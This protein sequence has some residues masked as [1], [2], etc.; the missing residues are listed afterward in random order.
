MEGIPSISAEHMTSYG[1]FDFSS[2]RYVPKEFYNSMS[3]GHITKNDI[4]IVKDGAT[5]GKVCL[6][7][8]ISRLIA[9]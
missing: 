2:I 8:T 1:K 7:E 6:V 5:T 4:L 9:P 3:H